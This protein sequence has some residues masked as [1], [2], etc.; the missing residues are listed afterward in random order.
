MLENFWWIGFNW[1]GW[2]SSLERWCGWL[3]YWVVGNL[4]LVY[5]IFSKIIGLYIFEILS[6]PQIIHFK[7]KYQK[8]DFYQPIWWNTKARHDGDGTFLLND[9]MWNTVTP[10][11]TAVWTYINGTMSS[12]S[13]VVQRW[14]RMQHTH[15]LYIDVGAAGCPDL[16]RQSG[17]RRA[18]KSTRAP[19][20]RRKEQKIKK[21]SGLLVKMDVFTIS[22]YR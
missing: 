21:Q 17:T 12:F 6:P 22:G 19:Y 4:K 9:E 20:Q 18:C 16:I 3:S 13:S 7:N 5:N 1:I 10:A 14:C 2:A 11:S 15:L 8:S